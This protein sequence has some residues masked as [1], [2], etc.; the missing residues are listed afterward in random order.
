LNALVKEGLLERVPRRGTFVISNGN[1]G[2]RN[3]NAVGVVMMSKG[4]VYQDIAQGITSGLIERELYPITINRKIVNNLSNVESFMKLLI[5]DETK[6]YG[7]I[8]NGDLD[9][10]FDFLQQNVHGFNNLVF[11]I[12]YHNLEKIETAKYALV[13]FTEAGRGIARHFISRGHKKLAFLAMPEPDYIC[14]IRS[15]QVQIMQGFADVCR[16]AGVD[17]S[18]EIFWKLLH[19]APLEDTMRELLNGSERPD[20]IFSYSDAYL[21]Y[22]IIPQL[23]KNGLKPNKDIEL[24]GFYNTHHSEECGFSSVSIREDKIAETAVKLL[25]NEID[26]QEVLIKPKLIIR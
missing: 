12:K 7:F 16:E 23:E 2:K 15:I 13:D 26:E 19:G 3:S 5:T 25:T 9:F 1:Y 8:V 21:R 22:F 24:F 14:P 17:F 11:I 4:D 20:A 18:D 6:P 10:P